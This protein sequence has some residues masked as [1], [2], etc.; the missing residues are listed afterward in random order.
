MRDQ[1]FTLDTT[2][3]KWVY[4]YEISVI[5]PTRGRTDLLYNCLKSLRD[6]SYRPA[7]LFEVILVIDY[8]DHETI[9]FVRS[10]ITEFNF[11]NRQ[12]RLANN[13]TCLLTH[14]SVF[15]QRDYNN[16]AAVAAK[17]DLVLVLNDDTL[18]MTEA[19]D[20]KLLNFYE[21]NRPVDD[22]MMI[23]VLDDTHNGLQVSNKGRDEYGP[24]FPV[25]TK[26]FVNLMG[27]VIPPE[28]K[29]WGADTA[30]FNI[31][32]SLG[33]CFMM[34]DIEIKHLSLHTNTRDIDAT[35]DHVEMVSNQQWKMPEF[36]WYEQKIRNAIKVGCMK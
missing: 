27:G 6:N 17:G 30:L 28:I 36:T 8:D 12:R 19:W 9:D 16:A 2:K 15:M 25:V 5:I 1:C 21:K 11:I 31:F 13:I 32:K 3:D 29:M 14:R 23:C 7:V 35:N 26:S 22:I 34:D 4:D 10:K 20:K 18:M 24:C 33:R